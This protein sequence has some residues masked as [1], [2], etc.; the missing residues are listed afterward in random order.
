MT[1]P[2][3]PAFSALDRLAPRDRQAMRIGA[4]IVAPVLAVV[5]VVQPYRRAQRE[6]S[7]ALATERAALASELAALRDAP[8]DA[9]LVRQGRRALVEEGAR[10]FDGA[11]AV[12]ASAE[13]ASWVADQA[14]EAGLELEDSETRAMTDVRDSTA[15]AARSR[16]PTDSR[17]ARGDVMGV[18]PSARS[19]APPPAARRTSPCRPHPAARSRGARAP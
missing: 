8:R 19:P 14:A 5:L 13:L 9:R 10:L 18:L 4:W 6:A 1:M 16:A 17:I 11:D 15:V 3:L 7:E 2:T 12:A